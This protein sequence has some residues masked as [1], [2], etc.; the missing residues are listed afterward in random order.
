MSPRLSLDPAAADRSLVQMLMFLYAA[1]L[2]A[3]GIALIVVLY[4]HRDDVNTWAEP[5]LLI[6]TL[7]LNLAPLG[8]LWRLRPR[9][10]A[11]LGLAPQR[12]ADLWTMSAMDMGSVFLVL[13][14]SGGFNTQYYHVAV[15]A[16]LV[17]TFMLGWRGSLIVLTAFL[18]TLIGVFSIAGFGLDGPWRTTEA[19]NTMPG[20][21]LTPVVVVL[22]SQYLAWLMRRL[23]DRSEV[24]SRTL[25]ETAALYSVARTAASE[26]G[27]DELVAEAVR[28][29]STNGRV[30][31]LAAWREP[32]EG[33]PPIAHAFALPGAAPTQPPTL[34][35]LTA[36]PEDDTPLEA[37]TAGGRRWAVWPIRSGQTRWGLLAASYGDV[38]GYRLVAATAELLSLGITR[39]SLIGEKELLAA[40]EERS[41]IAREIHD[42]VAQTIYMLSLSLERA[43]EMAG[44]D[45]VGE[46]LRRLVGY[47][48][49]ALLE[50]RHYIFDLKPLLSGDSSLAATIEG[51]VREFRAV[52]DLETTLEVEGDEPELPVTVT[53]ALYRIV[54]EALANAYR[55]AG[56]NAVGVEL[57]F[58]PHE[59]CVAVSDDGRGFDPAERGDGL[60]GRGL[61]NI[62]ER[63][64]EMGGTLEVTSAPDSG[65]TLSVVVPIA[66]AEPA[67]ANDG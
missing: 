49:E 4:G 26:T 43:A 23:G 32:A 65:T 31:A 9:L 61:R 18:G 1:R 15:V 47:S 41:R 63:A 64:S 22:V 2:P 28:L 8:Y 14:L 11:A 16:L 52:S 33:A 30:T 40:Q 55:H 35:T 56:A 42:G 59:L 57:R 44:D 48:K 37:T 46:Q 51:Q 58:R 29:V 13:G 20:V 38:E 5:W 21:M 53:S 67:E 7:A 60:S 34:L 45:E 62:S 17:P 54:Q 12:R 27:A 36:T 66:R 24:L 3:W 25:A 6:A 50:T 10:I 19:G 39:L